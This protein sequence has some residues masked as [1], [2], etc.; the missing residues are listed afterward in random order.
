MIA[1]ALAACDTDPGLR[2]VSF[3][4]GYAEY[5]AAREA[6]LRGLPGPVL[7]EPSGSQTITGDELAAAG[8]GGASTTAGGMAGGAA[9]AGASTFSDGD[10]PTA[11]ATGQPVP[12]ASPGGNL[13]ISDEQDFDAVAARESIQSDAARREAQRQAYQ[14]I[15]P[16]PLPERPRSTGPNLVEYALSTTNQPGEQVYSRSGLSMP[17]RGCG[18]YA[19]SDQAQQAFLEAGGPRRD[20]MGLD[21]DGDGFAC[22]W[23]PRPFRAARGG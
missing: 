19:T 22:S 13:G 20:R 6:E 11:G 5:T 23:D 14:V 2:G 3:D 4:Q 17:G 8:I 15:E 10:F 12:P 16:Q 1:L 21:P 9:T 18:D 7:V